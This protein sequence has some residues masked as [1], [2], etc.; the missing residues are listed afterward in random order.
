MLGFSAAMLWEPRRM[1]SRQVTEAKRLRELLNMNRTNGMLASIA[2]DRSN[3]KLQHDFLRQAS[4]PS[5]AESMIQKRS[6]LA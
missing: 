1:R 2:A 3:A 4:S 5:F 6:P